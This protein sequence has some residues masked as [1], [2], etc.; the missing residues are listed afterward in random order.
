MAENISKSKTSLNLSGLLFV[1]P[2]IASLGGLAAVL[3][4]AQGYRTIVTEPTIPVGATLTSWYDAAIAANHLLS[5]GR[6]PPGQAYD[7]V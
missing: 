1:T 7:S 2:T 4:F 3:L 5:P 6:T